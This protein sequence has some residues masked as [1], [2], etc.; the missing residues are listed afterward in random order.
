MPKLT[1]AF[2]NVSSTPKKYKTRPTVQR[3]KAIVFSVRTANSNHFLLCHSKLI[4]Y[5]GRETNK[6]HL[7]L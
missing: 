7:L 6:V 5:P 3:A 1:V 2:R 4:S